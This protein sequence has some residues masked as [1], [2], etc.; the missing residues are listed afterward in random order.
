MAKARLYLDM[1]SQYIKLSIMKNNKELGQAILETTEKTFND[2]EIVDY[3]RVADI[4]QEKLKELKLKPKE[5][6]SVIHSSQTI[7]RQFTIPAVEKEEEIVGALE[8]K[9]HE[10]LPDI[11]M[12]HVMSYRVYKKDD[13][14]IQGLVVLVPN[15][16]VNSY[17]SLSE[18]L[19]MSPEVLD[20]AVNCAAKAIESLYGDRCTMLIDLGYGYTNITLIQEGRVL[21]QRYLI[22]GLNMLEWNLKKKLDEEVAIT[23]CMEGDYRE[24]FTH[25][26]FRDIL[27]DT[28]TEVNNV[29][30]QMQDYINYNKL[31]ES[32]KGLLLYG[33]Y[34][35]QEYI[36]NYFKDNFNTSVETVKKDKAQLIN[37]I[38]CQIRQ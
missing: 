34:I 6:Y 17:V 16:I 37:L 22:N 15:E 23:Q 18:A 4:I 10:T 13:S 3:H 28:L 29:M 11:L 32:Y 25:D 5:F 1:N 26:A 33:D 27:D 12:T 20:V 7:L 36:T 30:Y 9:L 14:N 19:H 38:G 8:V 2:G 35:E 24:Y 21:T 31:E